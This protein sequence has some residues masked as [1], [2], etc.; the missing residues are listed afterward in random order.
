MGTHPAGTLIFAKRQNRP[1]DEKRRKKP[2]YRLPTWFF[3][4]QRVGIAQVAI[5]SFS[6]KRPSGAPPA[7]LVRDLGVELGEGQLLWVVSEE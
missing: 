5:Y 2:G 4:G 3:S 1:R 7:R 6:L